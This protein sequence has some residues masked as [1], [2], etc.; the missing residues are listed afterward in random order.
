MSWHLFLRGLVAT[1]ALLALFTVAACE[2]HSA[3]QTV[4]PYKKDQDSAEKSDKH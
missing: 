2:R 4:I 3:E 1:A